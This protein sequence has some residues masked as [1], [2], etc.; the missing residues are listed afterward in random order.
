[1][2]I[3]KEFLLKKL[4]KV[5]FEMNLDE[6]LEQIILDSENYN[7]F[8]KLQD[9]KQV[10]DFLCEKY[11]YSENFE[12]FCSI[13]NEYKSEVEKIFR[14]KD[15]K[16]LEKISGGMDFKKCLRSA[17]AMSM[18]G[19][20]LPINAGNRDGHTDNFY[21]ASQESDFEKR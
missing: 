19:S 20:S 3:V 13:V 5:V 4:L 16:E 2:I 21:F 18:A 7:K 8:L 12:N 9:E 6:I 17:S 11:N 14:D 1:M 10:Y 15:E